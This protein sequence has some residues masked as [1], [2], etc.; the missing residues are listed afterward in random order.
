MNE[1][2]LTISEVARLVRLSEKSV[3]K[4]A[5]AGR[6]PGAAKVGNQWRVNR[7]ELL[8]WLKAGG[9]AQFRSTSEGE[10]E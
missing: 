9:A 4:L 3:Y 1:A 5:Q 10:G 8:A 6:L 2:F 7:E